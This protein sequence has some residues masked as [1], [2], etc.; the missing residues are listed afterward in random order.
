[1][2]PADLTMPTTDLPLY[3]SHEGIDYK[4]C[5]KK[6][7]WRWR[8]GYVPKRKAIGALDFGTWV[9]EALALWYK[10]LRGGTRHN[11]Q[12]AD[13][14]GGIAE[15]AIA[16][17]AQDGASAEQLEKAEEL[18]MLGKAILTAYQERYADDGF[19]PIQAEIPMEVTVH[20]ADGNG[21]A[22]YKLK[23]D[24]AVRLN[25]GVWLVE[26]KTAKSIRTEHLVIDDQAR[27]YGALAEMELRRL[28]LISRTEKLKGIIYNYLRKGIPDER[29]VNAEGQALNKNGTVSKRQQAPLFLRHQVLLSDKAKAATLRRK[30]MEIIEITSM[31]QML[32]EGRLQPR[33]LEK[34][35]HWSCPKTCDFFPICSLE[36][37][38]A[39]ITAMER[40]LY[41]RQNPYLYDEEN[42]TADEPS[43]FE[44]G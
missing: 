34:T 25:G 42:D 31:T 16:W 39:D 35:P 29:E 3:R 27:P 40:S 9:H 33:W 12:L 8:K 44:M 22:V 7:Y 24:L 5:K 32:R 14:F 1:M 13:I 19:E 41:T 28:G 18:L 38:G 20:D 17:A 36:E 6:W 2:R 26:H 30:R 21:I 23:P 37:E 4:R 15:S 43:S 10:P 11:I